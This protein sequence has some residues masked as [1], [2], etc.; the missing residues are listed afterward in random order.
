MFLQAT[1]AQVKK[2]QTCVIGA[3]TQQALL[4]VKELNQIFLIQ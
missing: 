2:L 1:Q 3:H 4:S